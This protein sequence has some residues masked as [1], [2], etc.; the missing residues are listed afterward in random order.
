MGIALLEATRLSRRCWTVV[1][2]SDKFVLDSGASTSMVND[3][4]LLHKSR[5]TSIPIDTANGTAVGSLTDSVKFLSHRGPNSKIFLKN[6]LY[7][8]SLP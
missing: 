8:H 1:L 7:C 5:T 4:R 3:P 2:D 6:C